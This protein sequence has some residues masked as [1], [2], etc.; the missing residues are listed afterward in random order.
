MSRPLEAE[1]DL[2]RQDVRAWLAQQKARPGEFSDVDPDWASLPK[3]P[4]KD[5]LRPARL[6]SK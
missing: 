1:Q 5:Q 6:A 2:I 4:F 3:V